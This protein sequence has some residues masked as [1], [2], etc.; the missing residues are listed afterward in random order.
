MKH[1]FS[2]D[3]MPFALMLASSLSKE[4]LHSSHQ[5]NQNEEQ[6]DVFGH[7]T[8]LPLASMP[9]LHD[10]YSIL[11]VTIIF[12]CQDDR[13]EVQHDPFWL[14]NATLKGGAT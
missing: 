1:D 6:H 7:V 3:V 5:D 10:T 8:Q 12:L 4:P 11:Y 13:S 2:G 9:V 14:Y